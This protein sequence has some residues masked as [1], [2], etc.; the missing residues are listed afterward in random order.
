MHRSKLVH[1]L[2]LYRT[3]WHSHAHRSAHSRHGGHH[4]AHRSCP[5]SEYQLIFETSDTTCWG[6]GPYQ[7]YNTFVTIEAA[8]DPSLPSAT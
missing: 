5:G 8:L 6:L 7:T 2:L 3:R 1:V 4:P